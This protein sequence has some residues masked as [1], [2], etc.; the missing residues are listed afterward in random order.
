MQTPVAEA[1]Q[2]QELERIA[3]PEQ[4]DQLMQVVSLRLWIPLAALGGVVGLVLLWAIIGAIPINVM[5]RGAFIYPRS[6]AGAAEVAQFQAPGAGRLIDLRVL[7]GDHVRKGMLI[8]VIDQPDLRK[9]LEIAREK[10]DELLATQKN[11]VPLQGALN[12]NQLKALQDQRASLVKKIADAQALLAS[13]NAG[14][15]QAVELNTRNLKSRLADA[16]H[17]RASAKRN[18]E[19]QTKLKAL[20]LISDQ[21]FSAAEHQYLDSD[22]TVSDLRA[23]LAQQSSAMLNARRTADGNTSNLADLKAQ[24][25]NLNSSI[26]NQRLA[27]EQQRACDQA[28]LQDAEGQVDQL[29]HQLR[30]SSFIVSDY[31]GTILEVSAVVGQMVGPG[32]ALG[33]I[34]VSQ[35]SSG[36]GTLVPSADDHALLQAVCYFTVGDGKRINPGMAVQITPDTVKRE[37]YGG[38]VGHVTYVS[39]FPVT[40]QGAVNM[41][42][43]A[44]VAQQVTADGRRIEVI[45]ELDPDAHS[46]SGYRWTSSSGPKLSLT[47][48]TTATMRVT[49]QREKPIT[50]LLPMLKN[51]LGLE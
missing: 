28:A 3:N 39:A 16:I 25:V 37:Q 33:A 30:S 20:G 2:S 24:L 51:M 40:D 44:D 4:L 6:E 46:Y 9:N 8:G 47:A 34:D 12:A 11:S 36:S 15:I 27:Y 14:L 45:A 19:A 23:Q 26:T 48:G 7:R 35:R 41:L 18:Y 22:H 13:S 10:R 17:E 31:D 21:V 43:S 29:E 5:G 32:T 38:I 1:Q 50:L 49:V 42:N